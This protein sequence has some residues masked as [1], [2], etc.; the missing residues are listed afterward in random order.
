MLGVHYCSHY[1]WICLTIIFY[2]LL[3]FFVTLIMYCPKRL[4]PVGVFYYLPCFTMR[5]I[6]S[7]IQNPPWALGVNAVYRIWALVNMCF[8]TNDPNAVQL[9]EVVTLSVSWERLTTAE[10]Q[11]ERKELS[12]WHYHSQSISINTLD[13]RIPAACI[14]ICKALWDVSLSVLRVHF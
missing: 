8:Y 5:I 4:S 7:S 1:F 10:D 13:T 11:S 9:V 12:S 6:S 14:S 3:L 2:F